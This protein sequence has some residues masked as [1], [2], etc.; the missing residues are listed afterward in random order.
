MSQTIRSMGRQKLTVVAVV[1]GAVLFM[2]VN[3]FSNSAFRAMQVDLTEGSLYT[4]SE[5]T[6]KV[7]AKVD[8]P[9]TARLYFSRFMGEQS[10]AHARYYE[11]VREL[12]ERY[13]NLTQGRLR[14]QLFN[15]EPFSDDED[16]A[17]AYGL[18]GVPVNE[19]G[20]L[21]YFG[22]AA[23]NSTD[24][25]EIIPFFSPEREAF[26]QYDLTKL[27]N[28]LATPKK[29]VVGVLSTLPI[30]GGFLP[31]AG[32][33]PRWTVIDQINEFFEVQ[34]VP[35]DAPVIDKDV[36]ILMLV[37]PKALSAKTRYGI[38]QFVMRG[39]KVL[40]FV[41]PVAEVDGPGAGYG[42][43]G[44][45]E[46]GD[47]M[48]SWGVELRKDRV[49]GDLDSARRVNVRAGSQV[50]IADYV[51]WLS[52]RPGNFDRDDPAM[53]ALKLI[54][55]GTAGILDTVKGA[56]TKFTPL[57]RTGMRS[58]AIDAKEFERQPDVI[59]LFRNFKAGT[60]PLTLAARITGPAK[61]AFPYGRP[62]DA[63]ADAA[64]KPEDKPKDKPKHLAASAK[65]IQVIV[66]ADV[67]MLHD[68]LWV[69]AQ[70]MLG[71]RL[72]VPFANNADFIIGVLENLAGGASLS[73]L[74]GRTISS[75]PFELVREIRQAAER[76][77]RTKEEELQK[78]L[79]A[80]RADLNN[81][82]R[83]ENVQSGELILKPADR[84]RME[85]ARLEMVAIRKEL[86]SVQH[87]LRKD[88]DSLDSWL[89]FFNIAAIPLVLAFGTL[90]FAVARRLRRRGGVVQTG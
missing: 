55:V 29:T 79:E 46:L 50:A 19:T 37:H 31:G 68:N 90:I 63:K 49:A 61:S 10:P 2:A 41:D 72:L 76:R 42:K 78:K 30:N 44:R 60:E 3:V 9:I 5:G 73:E 1:L 34:P 84:E 47:L 25:F 13:E 6:R 45:S 58:M 20:D 52:L 33:R 7:L 4:L 21:G 87:E 16:S 11:R 23:S 12:L 27:V 43:P 85:K 67:D 71:K 62:K 14:L 38:D 82:I 81:L 22:L 75:R 35:P 86:R 80:V 89:K 32:N 40:A 39:G 51:G 57:I 18:T 53:G 24:D 36:D 69:E 54:N 59:G 28:A 88:I 15:P 56:T 48:K 65:D 17:V 64:A 26:L 70:D 74:R 77:F 8:E 66:V 83:R